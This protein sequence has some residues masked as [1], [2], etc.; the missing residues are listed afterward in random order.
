MQKP[1]VV[2]A[3]VS[4]LAAGCV[5]GDEEDFSSEDWGVDEQ[6]ITGTTV[7]FQDGIIE[8]QVGGE[9]HTGILL[10]A[11]TAGVGGCPNPAPAIV[12][13]SED[14]VGPATAPSSVGL[15]RY[16]NAGTAVVRTGRFVNTSVDF[17]G[18]V[19]QSSG[20]SNAQIIPRATGAASTF[21]NRQLNCFE[22]AVNGSTGQTVLK[23]A[24]VT[25]SSVSG[26]DLI[27]NG[28]TLHT[29]D[30]GAVCVDVLTNQAVGML[31]DVT[32]NQNNQTTSATIR[33]YAG[34]QE[35]FDG[36]RTLSLVRTHS[37]NARLAFYNDLAARKCLDVPWGTVWNTTVNQFPC[38]S[39]QGSGIGISQRFWLDYSVDANRPRF[40]SD[41]SGKC[42]DIPSSS[43]ASGQGIQQFP[44]HTGMNQRF[45][46]DLWSTGQGWRV[47]GAH[48]PAHNLCLSVDGG[49]TPQSRPIEQRTCSGTTDQRWFITWVP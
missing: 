24:T 3:F 18:A 27:A 22:Y 11:C 29:R 39:N 35:W 8:V 4:L 28:N 17:P 25:V 38:H 34:M 43:L 14:W 37:S 36:L 48:D 13:T 20:W 49:P 46:I 12:L 42:L 45:D 32:I 26:E 23:R 47:R 1:S 19:I 2:C 44:C 5:A 40:V 10:P 33:R 15:A 30:T 7:A 31:R 16:A 41:A 9:S 6:A 21:L